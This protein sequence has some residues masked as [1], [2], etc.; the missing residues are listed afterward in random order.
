MSHVQPS[1]GFG[2]VIDFVFDPDVGS[3]QSVISVAELIALVHS[4]NHYA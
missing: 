2:R 1:S 3:Q 4:T